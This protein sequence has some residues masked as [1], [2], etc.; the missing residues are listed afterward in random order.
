MN[1]Q[2]NE[3]GQVPVEKPDTRWR[4]SS[5]PA[6]PPSDAV[7]D[8]IWRN[9]ERRRRN[10]V[11]RGT[12]YAGELDDIDEPY[13]AW[14]EDP[15]PAGLPATTCGPESDSWPGDDDDEDEE[16]CPAE[17]RPGTLRQFCWTRPY[18]NVGVSLS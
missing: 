17:S 8:A 12:G 18:G 3:E 13:E 2:R 11:G 4:R 15:K 7:D 14:L 6:M 16:N 10:E 5:A 9:N 1:I